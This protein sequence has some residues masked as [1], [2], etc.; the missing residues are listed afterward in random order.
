LPDDLPQVPGVQASG[1]YQAGERG[2]DIGG[3][4]YDVIQ[5]EG[6]RLMI[7]VGDVSGRGLQAAATMAAL[8]FA[9]RA[10]ALQGDDPDDILV[11]LAR[12]VQIGATGQFATILCTV[13]DADSHQVTVTS[14]GHLPPLLVT[15]VDA[16]FLS[17]DV[18][19]PVGVEPS[20]TYSCSTV[21][22]G[23]S[24]TLL[25]YTDGLVERRG[26]SLD[27]GLSRLRSAAV[28]T[29]ESLEA[30]LER[31]TGELSEGADDDV[32]IVGVRWTT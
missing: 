18:G 5:L 31:L 30:L 32:A 27:D 8:R 11:K 19:L 12:V 26:E 3:D 14:A 23:P 6:R 21:S 25:A 15:G 7:V 2:V 22:L 28:R 9:I 17:V 4:W 29:G 16:K 13:F 1:R 10:Y 24:G 20:P